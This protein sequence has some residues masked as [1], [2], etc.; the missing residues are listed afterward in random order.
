MDRLTQREFEDIIRKL[1]PDTWVQLQERGYKP[2]LVQ[3]IPAL[4]MPGPNLYEVTISYHQVTIHLK[5]AGEL[6]AFLKAF[7]IGYA[8]GLAAASRGV[9]HGR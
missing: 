2:E 4:H 3:L 7:G 9:N 6:T 8:E 5:T 1:Y